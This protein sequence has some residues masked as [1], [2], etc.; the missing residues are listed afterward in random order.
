M[1]KF[2]IIILTAVFLTSCSKKEEKPGQSNS[3]RPETPARTVK[4]EKVAPKDLQLYA[5]ITGK[6][7]GITDIVF[8]SELG[9]KV[10]SVEKKLG[11]QVKKG[12]AIAYLDSQSY[13]ITYDQ[14][15]SELKSSEANLDALNIKLEATQKLF[16]SGKVSRFELANDQ[17][18]A[19]RAEAAVEGARANVERARL[20]YENSKFLSPADG[21][22]AQINIKQGQF[23]GAGQPVA[24]I[25]DCS[26]LIIRTGVGES[27]IG[28]VRTGSV[29]EI[30]HNASGQKIEGKITAIAKK[31]DQTG[32]YPVEIEI[33]NGT[34]GFF[35]GMIISGKVESLKLENVI[36]TGFDN[37]S[38]EFG[39]YF[40]FA[41]MDGTAVKKQVQPGKKYG[42]FVLINEGLEAGEELI[43][44]GIDGINGGDKVR[45]F[46][47]AKK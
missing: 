7:E 29:A 38:E 45:I 30:T 42:S 28:F 17:S 44:S 4:I 13:K 12:E 15:R 14:T 10:R 41:V 35:P 18:S 27:D 5:E 32:R 31:I 36:Y 46:S 39:K 19:K 3:M 8:Y 21:F 33:E 11:D 20:N 25:V 2:A 24:S 23:I 47:E 34:N 37:I 40:V 22:I 26:K 1:K 6:L 9:G 43:V 16:E